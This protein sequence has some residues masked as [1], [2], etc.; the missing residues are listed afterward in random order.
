MVV[1]FYALDSENN[2]I[3]EKVRVAPVIH[4]VQ[5]FT[6]FVASIPFGLHVDVLVVPEH[7]MDFFPT[8]RKSSGNLM[9][10]SRY[11]YWWQLVQVIA[12]IVI[13][14]GAIFLLR[15]AVRYHRRGRE[16]VEKGEVGMAVKKES[17]D[18]ISEIDREISDII[19]EESS[20]S[21]GISSERKKAPAIKR[22]PADLASRREDEKPAP[23][24]G[25]KAQPDEEEAPKEPSTK[26][27]SENS[28]LEK[29]GIIIRKG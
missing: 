15:Y 29:D 28:G 3:E 13:F 17:D 27:R 23:E 14:I 9:V 12:L 26:E 19:D 6:T 21:K 16:Y 24:S 18:V 4:M 20:E 1:L 2:I 5:F 10:I 7:V 22:K 25:K 11:P 8:L